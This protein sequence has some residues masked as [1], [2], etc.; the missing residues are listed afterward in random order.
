MPYCPH[1]D[2][3]L[4]IGQAPLSS[5][6]R[7]RL[8]LGNQHDDDLTLIEWQV[9]KAAAQYFGVTDWTSKVDT[10]L[11]YRENVKRMERIGTSG[12]VGGATAKQVHARDK[13]EMRWSHD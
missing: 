7:R 13:A 6:E 12:A 10:S 5:Y 4:K 2:Q 1:C 8:P 9:V 3:K 11:S